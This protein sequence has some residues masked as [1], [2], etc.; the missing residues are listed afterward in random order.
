M[1]CHTFR[2]TGEL[3]S[4]SSAPIH[5][6]STGKTPG[7]PRASHTGPAQHAERQLEALDSVQRRSHEGSEST[8]LCPRGLSCPCRSALSAK[9]IER[10]HR[11][12]SNMRSIGCRGMTIVDSPSEVLIYQQP[13]AQPRAAWWLSPLTTLL[14]SH[15]HLSMPSGHLAF[16]F[17]FV[18]ASDLLHFG[19]LVWRIRAL[20]YHCLRSL[21]LRYL[22]LEAPTCNRR[23]GPVIMTRGRV[24]VYDK[25]V[26]LRFLAK[27]PESASA[28]GRYASPIPLPSFHRLCF[29]TSHCDNALA[30]HLL[31]APRLPPTAL[32]STPDRRRSSHL[33]PRLTFRAMPP[34]PTH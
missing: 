18:P 23:V 14:C 19:A 22:R 16:I 7:S 32:Q 25:A 20:A 13:F 6:F 29:K 30:S 26:I 28:I 15:V 34:W 33:S 27:P 3:L 24:R 5:V 17:F 2:E 1:P 8:L 12:P 10:R 31:L 11:T 21:P 4:A 9:G